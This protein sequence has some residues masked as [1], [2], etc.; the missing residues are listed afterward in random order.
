MYI[1]DSIKCDVSN[2][3]LYKTESLSVELI[4]KQVKIAIILVYNPPSTCN[5]VIDD[6]ANLFE[7]RKFNQHTII[8]GDFNINWQKP[9]TCTI[10]DNLQ[11][12]MNLNGLNQLVTEPTRVTNISSTLIDLVFSNNDKIIKN[13]MVLK[14]DISDHYTVKFCINDE[15]KPAIEQYKRHR[16]F[17]KFSDQEFFDHA[18]YVNFHATEQIMCPILLQ[19]T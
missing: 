16:D 12:L 5:L 4:T 13:M 11:T 1:K 8:L 7:G 2:V 10:K 6:F 18:K 9:S 14:T 17:R 19:N 15:A 3:S